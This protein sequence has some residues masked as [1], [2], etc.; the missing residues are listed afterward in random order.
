MTGKFAKL[1]KNWC[2]RGWTNIPR[3]IVNWTN[4]KYYKIPQKTFYVA[5]SCDGQ[6]DF[7]SFA[8]LPEHHA[9]LDQMVKEG[10]VE[11]CP[12]GDIIMPW[13]KFKKA[14]NPFLKEIHWCVTGLCNLNCRHCYMEAP[15]GR[16]GELPYEKMIHIIEQFEQANV[17]Q[18]S[19]TGGEPFLRKDLLDIMTVLA[20]KKIW[21]S[22]IYT[23]GTLISEAVLEKIKKIGFSPYFQ[24]SFDGYGGHEYMR[25][26]KGIEDKVIKSLQKLRKAGFPLIIASNFD[27]ENLYQLRNTYELM[28]GLDVQAWRIG[29]PLRIGNW[30]GSTTG[31][32]V[33]EQTNAYLKVLEWWLRDNRPFELVLGLFFRAPARGNPIYS[34][35]SKIQY[36]SESF[37]CGSC[38]EN[39]NL[40]PDGTLLPCPGYV[41]SDLQALMPNLLSEKLSKVWTESFL[42][43]LVEIKKG[44]L[45]KYNEDCRQCEF[46]EVCGTGC[47]ASALRETGNLMTKDPVACV[48]WKGQYKQQFFELAR[49]I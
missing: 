30:K 33:N 40:L 24:I 48:L 39:P 12:K 27:S 29:T 4:S 11:I 37:D 45:L 16:Y 14:N 2:L 3:V 44:E 17:M 5:E 10:I 1:T 22:E 36:T 34:E 8:F 21:I 46:F 25:G 23:N 42:R 19:L 31:L 13:Q 26:R 43:S 6:T 47:R 38:R 35:G 41:D 7:N 15:S 32:T 20:E 49:Q 28:C 9:L 18:V